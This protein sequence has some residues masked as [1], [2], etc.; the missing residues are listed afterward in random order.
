MLQKFKFSRVYFI[1]LFHLTTRWVTLLC[2][3][4][5]VFPFLHKSR[6][7]HLPRVPSSP[8]KTNKKKKT[9]KKTQKSNRGCY[10]CVSC[11]V[12]WEETCL[13]AGNTHNHSFRFVCLMVICHKRD[14]QKQGALVNVQ[15]L[16]FCVL[17]MQKGATLL[18]G[19]VSGHLVI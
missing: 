18:F 7:V 3:S 1:P 2:S 12:G 16:D 14:L 6:K 4:L 11:T 19:P 8:K 5:F 13:Y 9:K 17:R 10:W 15:Y